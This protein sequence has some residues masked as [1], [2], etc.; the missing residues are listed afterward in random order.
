[1]RWTFRIFL[2]K[3]LQNRQQCRPFKTQRAQALLTCGVWL[4]LC[5]H[6]TLWTETKQLAVHPTPYWC[7][8]ACVRMAANNPAFVAF[9]KFDFSSFSGFRF[10]NFSNPWK[11]SR[12]RSKKIIQLFL[13]KK[14]AM[15]WSIPGVFPHLQAIFFPFV[16]NWTLNDIVD[17]SIQNTVLFS[18]TQEEYQSTKRVPKLGKCGRRVG[19]WEKKRKQE[20]GNH[21]RGT[22]ETANRKQ[23]KGKDKRTYLNLT[24]SLF[25][26]MLTLNFGQRLMMSLKS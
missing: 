4:S 15:T 1:M 21:E 18:W 17:V 26:G 3:V 6:P 7:T 23:H 24:S 20:N 9:L 25:K 8:P 14:D 12:L 22:A 11:T 5:C 19:C 16:E 13:Q 2:L 10:G